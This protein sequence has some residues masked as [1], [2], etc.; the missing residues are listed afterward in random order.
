MVAGGLPKS[1]YKILGLVS[2]GEG[3]TQK[4]LRL[5]IKVSP[6]TVKYALKV[7]KSK[8]LITESVDPSDLRKRAYYFGGQNGSI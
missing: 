6:R 3:V 4:D 1:F 7:L 8:G 5:K 2:K